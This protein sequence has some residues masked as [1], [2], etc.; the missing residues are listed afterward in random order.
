MIMELAK[1]ENKSITEVDDWAQYWLSRALQQDP[2]AKE[3]LYAYL[4]ES[5]YYIA[6][7]LAEKFPLL[8]WAN[9]FQEAEAILLESDSLFSRY[10]STRSSVITYARMKIDSKVK[11]A[12]IS[13]GIRSDAGLLRWLTEKRLRKYLKNYGV[14]E[15]ELADL[16]LAWQCFQEIYVPS[17][18]SRKSLLMP[19]K[20]CYEEIAKRY[21]QKSTT[22]TS[23]G[24]NIAEQIAECVRAARKPKENILRILF[25]DSLDKDPSKGNDLDKVNN[26][27]EEDDLDEDNNTREDKLGEENDFENLEEVKSQQI[28]IRDCLISTFEALPTEAKLML[29]LYHGLNLTHTDIVQ[30]LKLN[31]ISISQS[32]VSRRIKDSKRALLREL[33]IGQINQGKSLSLDMNNEIA[34]ELAK[35]L[36]IWL[37]PFCQDPINDL[38]TL[39][40]QPKISSNG[41]SR[42]VLS[43]LKTDLKHYLEMKWQIKAN[44]LD[45]VDLA[46]GKYVENW[47]SRKD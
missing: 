15:Q 38:L 14:K 44:S 34:D 42:E 39:R 30:V 31:G 32:T 1:E 19:T 13:T 17:Y 41:I 25:S 33:V 3:H 18:T 9:C 43:F 35:Q 47:L 5:C 6:V 22:K 16:I 37:D 24:E 40:I 8:D 29:R 46:V 23:S 28:K 11:E 10:D 4:Q 27:N 2:V 12:L 36:H 45:A 21:N 7:Q 26:S 20:E